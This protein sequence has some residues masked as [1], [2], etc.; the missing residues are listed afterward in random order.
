MGVSVED[1]TALDRCRHLK[2]TPAKTKFI[3]AEP[4]IERIDTI[5]LDGID[6]LIVGGESGHGCRPIEK[7]WVIE[8]VNMSRGSGTAFFFKQWGGINKAKNGSLLDG[9]EYKAYPTQ[10]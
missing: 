4:L 7:E 1:K 3:S 9:K 5:E 2:N 8:L 6:W 10:E